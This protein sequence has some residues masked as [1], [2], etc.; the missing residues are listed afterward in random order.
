[1]KGELG[2]LKRTVMHDLISRRCYISVAQSK[3][4]GK[5]SGSSRKTQA[6]NHREERLTHIDKTGQFEN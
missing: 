6:G 5:S 2:N 4:A 1:L 3:T